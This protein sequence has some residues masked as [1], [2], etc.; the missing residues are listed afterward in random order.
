[1]KFKQVTLAAT[2]QTLKSLLGT[3]APDEVDVLILQCPTANTGNGF[4][5]DSAAQIFELVKAAAPYVV[6]VKEDGGR[7]DLNNLY[8]RGTASDKLSVGYVAYG[9]EK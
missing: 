6:P 1:M 7:I 8:V 5:G 2:E 4:F 9:Q 3:G